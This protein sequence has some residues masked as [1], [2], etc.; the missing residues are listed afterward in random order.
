MVGVIYVYIDTVFGFYGFC[1]LLLF[2]N[3][4]VGCFSMTVRTPAVLSALYA[5]VLYFCICPCSE[6][7]SMFHMERHSRNTL[8]IIIIIIIIIITIIITL[9]GMCHYRANLELVGS[10]WVYCDRMRQQSW[11]TTSVSVW[12]HVVY[13]RRSNPKYTVQNHNTTT[14]SDISSST[15]MIV[16][17]ALAHTTLL[18]LFSLTAWT[19]VVSWL[20]AATT[21]AAAA[22]DYDDWWWW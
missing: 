4:F 3:C 17:Q 1:F 5:C 6:Q 16:A 22:D 19:A 21:T 7:F 13:Q 9:P 18:L 2:F 11:Y 14:S 15:S 8:I 10:V 20:A 12:Q